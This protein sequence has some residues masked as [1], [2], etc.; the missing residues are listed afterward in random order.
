LNFIA[1][2]NTEQKDTNKP[3]IEFNSKETSKPH[4]DDRKVAETSR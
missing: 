2:E 4:K 1:M 3:D